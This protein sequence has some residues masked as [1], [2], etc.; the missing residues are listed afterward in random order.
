M[1]EAERE[2]RGGSVNRRAERFRAPGPYPE[3]CVA[4]RNPFY[5]R[6]LLDDFA[7]PAS[8]L[9]AITQY[10]Y[11]HWWAEMEGDEELAEILEGFALVE[12][13]H[14]DMLARVILLLGGDPRLVSGDGVPWCSTNTYYGEG[15]CDRL[16]ANLAGE[17]GAYETYLRHAEMIEDPFVSALLRRFAVD[18]QF[19]ARLTTS[20][21]QRRC[22]LAGDG[23]EAQ[24]EEPPRRGWRR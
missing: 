12:M 10:L 14:F 11:H 18:E 17:R 15:V 7:G 5:A 3:I 2:R 6:I 20:V 22:G 16:A 24:R 8:E 21:L 13:D 9:T 19:H 4:G 23:R 1:V